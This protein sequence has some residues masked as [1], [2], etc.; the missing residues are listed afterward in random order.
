MSV[1]SLWRPHAPSLSLPFFANRTLSS[2]PKLQTIVAR[3]MFAWR[4]LKNICFWSSS[5]HYTNLVAGFIRNDHTRSGIFFFV[6]HSWNCIRCFDNA[7]GTCVCA[8]SNVN[9]GFGVI[10]LYAVAF[11]FCFFNCSLFYLLTHLYKGFVGPCRRTV[12]L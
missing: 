5:V 4:C 2:T 8:V 7:A 6:P 12:T 1:A 11:R 9:H 3:I 10:C